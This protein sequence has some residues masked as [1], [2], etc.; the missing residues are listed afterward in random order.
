MEAAFPLSRISTF[1]RQGGAGVC[2]SPDPVYIH[3]VLEQAG[4]PT[5]WACNS[6][7]GFDPALRRR[8]SMAI[9]IRTPPAAAR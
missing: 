2:D 4:V 7:S 5:L 1:G 3:S 9:E 6:L 8:I